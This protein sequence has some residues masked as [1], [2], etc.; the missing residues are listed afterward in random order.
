MMQLVNSQTYKRAYF[1]LRGMF[2]CQIY[3]STFLSK[4]LFLIA[5]ENSLTP[6]EFKILDWYPSSSLPNDSENL[7]KSLTAQNFSG[8]RLSFSSHFSFTNIHF[9]FYSSSLLNSFLIFLTFS[10]F[11]ILREDQPHLIADPGISVHEWS[12][13]IHFGFVFFRL[14]MLLTYG[15]ALLYVPTRM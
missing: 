6:S 7:Q 1:E 10:S 3:D 12:R 9:S 14:S 4:S 5:L 2:Q 11:L 13:K 8:C 15:L